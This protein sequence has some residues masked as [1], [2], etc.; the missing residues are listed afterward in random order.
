[1]IYV[2]DILLNWN[3]EVVYDF[4]E[5]EKTDKLDH[6]KKIPLLRVERGIISDVLNFKVKFDEALLTKIDSQAEAYSSKRIVKSPYTFL[7]SDSESVVGV[8]CDKYGNVKYR[9]KLILDEE[10]EIL[11]ISCRLNKVELSYEKG[12]RINSDYFL[13]RKESRI[14]K[15]LIDELENSYKNKNYEKIKYLYT[16]YFNKMINDPEEAYSELINTLS[17][18][19]NYRHNEL[20]D[21]LQLIG[22]KN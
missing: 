11:C 17:M 6:I 22:N 1:M 12:E 2:Y 3:K 4:F 8:K 10:E 13:T 7:I 21:L 5:W 20:Y 15:Y 18:E 9:S 19:I 16:E 14:K